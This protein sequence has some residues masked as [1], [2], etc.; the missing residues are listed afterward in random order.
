MLN[1]TTDHLKFFDKS[2]WQFPE[3][4]HIYVSINIIYQCCFFFH[5][6]QAPNYGVGIFHTGHSKVYHFLFFIIIMIKS[7]ICCGTSAI[8][9]GDVSGRIFSPY[10]WLLFFFVHFYQF[11]KYHENN[12]SEKSGMSIFSS[13]WQAFCFSKPPGSVVVL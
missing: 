11:L 4:G 10:Y 2:S 5:H 13:T 3:S 6:T 7:F 1:N 9:S 12:L 8:L